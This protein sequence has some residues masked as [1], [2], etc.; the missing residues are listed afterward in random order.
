M[1]ESGTD[2][3]HSI[4]LIAPMDVRRCVNLPEH[5]HDDKKFDDLIRDDSKTNLV[6]NRNLYRA[7]RL[8]RVSVLEA[9]KRFEEKQVC[10]V[11]Q[12]HNNKQELSSNQSSGLIG[13]GLVMRHGHREQLSSD[14]VRKILQQRQKKQRKLLEKAN[15]QAGRG[16]RRRIKTVSD[17]SGLLASPVEVEKEMTMPPSMP[18]RSC[19]PS[20][21]IEATQPQ[22]SPHLV[23][24][25]ST[26]ERNLPFLP[27]MSLDDPV[28]Q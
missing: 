19:P 7:H 14:A 6:V 27:P 12:E 17:M 18:S 16:R 1:E 3:D 10:R 22:N 5:D 26:S 9:S 8:M 24:F 28:D 20:P 13:A 23:N 21:A 15:K 25:K 11:L 2:E 4:H